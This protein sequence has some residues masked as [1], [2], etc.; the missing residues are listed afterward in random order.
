MNTRTLN[1]T[2]ILIVGLSFNLHAQTTVLYV[3]PGGKGDGSS[4]DKAT[5][6]LQSTLKKAKNGSQIWVAA[7]IYFP[8][9]GTDR[10]ISFEI[11][12]G[13]A[14]YGGFAGH[15]KTTSQRSF[16]QHPTIL[17][18]NIGSEDPDDNSY[19]VLFTRNTGSSTLLDG[20]II[21]GGNANGDGTYSARQ[22]SGGGLYNEGTAQGQSNPTIANC[23]FIDN[24]AKDGGAIYNNGKGGEASP[25]LTDCYFE[26]N[27]SYLDGGAVYNDGRTNGLSNPSF[28]NCTFAKNKGNYG[29]AVFN[30]GMNGRAEPHFANCVFST[31]ESFVKGG[32][33]FHLSGSKLDKEMFGNSVFNNNQA[34]DH[35]SNDVHHY[36]VATRQNTSAPGH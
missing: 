14:L 6:D 8:T 9:D 28:V 36:L 31:N 24:F 16:L 17:S 11:P 33:V 21:S 35:E 2:I 5:N 32:A 34:L 19:N 30:Y 25:T 1:N 4:W 7:G 29:G 18:G 26:N 12:D 27:I 23:T 15:E 20:F 13:V 3:S 10:N 22:R